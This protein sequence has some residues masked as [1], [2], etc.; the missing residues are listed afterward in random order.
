MFL[1][2]SWMHLFG[3]L[4]FLWIF[5][6]N[7]EATTGNFTFFIFYILGGL[8]AS[9]VH[10]YF[11][12]QGLELGLC[13]MPCETFNPCSPE[14]SQIPACPGY[15][16]SLGASGAIS[17][18][19]GAYLVMFPKSRIKILVLIFFRTFKIPA[20]IFLGLWFAQ[21]LIYGIGGLGLSAQNSGVA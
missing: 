13:C 18:V 15:T 4:L 6:D 3:N 8:A 12:Q 17:A 14:S 11:N 19:M 21:Q 1:H 20:F 10:I 16:P 7:I 2:G 5:A 9:V